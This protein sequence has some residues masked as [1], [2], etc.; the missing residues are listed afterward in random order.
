MKIDDEPI[1]F[2]HHTIVIESI[3]S[4]TKAMGQDKQCGTSD[5]ITKSTIHN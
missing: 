3:V 1:M 2:F 4:K 5:I